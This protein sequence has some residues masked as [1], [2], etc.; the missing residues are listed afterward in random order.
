MNQVMMPQSFKTQNH[1]PPIE[2]HSPPHLQAQLC[3]SLHP[4]YFIHAGKLCTERQDCIAVK[5]LG[6]RTRQIHLNARSTTQCD[7]G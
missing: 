2:S 5:R 3:S 6:F 1:L 4:L 7:L